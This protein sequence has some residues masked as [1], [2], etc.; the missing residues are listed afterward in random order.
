MWHWATGTGSVSAPRACPSAGSHGEHPKTHLSPALRHPRAR[1]CPCLA[2]LKGATKENHS[3]AAPALQKQ[4][5][6]G[7]VGAQG[8][9]GCPQSP[10]GS[11]DRAQQSHGSPPASS[12]WAQR[13][14]K[15][16]PKEAAGTAGGVGSQGKL[17]NK[18]V[19]H[20]GER[21]PEQS[22]AFIHKQLLHRQGSRPG[23]AKHLV[24]ALSFPGWA[25][26]C[27]HSPTGA[28]WEWTGSWIQ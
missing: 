28:N 14:T 17:K 4:K 11:R 6:R 12:S 24:P 22:V 20:R 5:G 18:Q 16:N 3:E 7:G 26:A 23:S 2:C 13:S 27:P 15:K 1:L 10:T 8:T 21:H 25:S 9:A 19:K